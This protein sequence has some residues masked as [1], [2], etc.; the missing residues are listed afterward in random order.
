MQPVIETEPIEETSGDDWIWPLAL[1]DDND[2]P[3]DLT[4]CTFDGAAIKWRGGE[5]PLT[6]ANGRLTVDAATGSITVTVA[7]ADNAIVP[8]GQRSR[9]VLPIVDTLNRKST[10]LIIP[11]RVIAP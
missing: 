2:A 6:C 7:R 9:A 1:T 5:L 3:V 10:L 4:G 8:D 11:I